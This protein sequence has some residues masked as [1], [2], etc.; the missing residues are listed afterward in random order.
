ML[1][2]LYGP[3]SASRPRALSTPA[4]RSSVVTLSF[5]PGF[6]L[7]LKLAR[8]E[9]GRG[10]VRPRGPASSLARSVGDSGSRRGD[11]TRSGT[12]LYQQHGDLG[13]VQDHLRHAHIDTTR[14]YA[15]GSTG[16][17]RAQRTRWPS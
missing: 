12:R 2:A 10:R 5:P 9:V 7:V 1:Q 13:Q 15:A 14:I 4:P 6:D 8:G 17:T 3:L 16:A 11:Y